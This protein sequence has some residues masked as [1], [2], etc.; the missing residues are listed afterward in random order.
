MA[1]ELDAEKIDRYG[2]LINVIYE[3]FP[4]PSDLE[5]RS[6]EFL[7]HYHKKGESLIEFKGIMDQVE[8]AVQ[9]PRE[10]AEVYNHE[11]GNPIGNPVEHQEMYKYMIDMHK[12]MSNSDPYAEEMDKGNTE[13]IMNY[14]FYRPLRI[15]FSVPKFGQEIPMWLAGVT[16]LVLA[17]LGYLLTLLDLPIINYIAFAL[18]LIGCIGV[19]LIGIG[20]LGLRDEVVNA[21]KNERREEALR[22]YKAAKREKKR[23]TSW[24]PLSRSG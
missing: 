1:E 16:S 23:T 11:I 20:M 9:R 21:G 14:Y 8:M 22:D 10:F 17:T 6:P 3:Y 2:V 5:D 18:L 19:L 24:N 7:Y 12:K 13:G 15:P 4:S